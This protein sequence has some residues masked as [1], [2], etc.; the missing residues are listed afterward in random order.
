MPKKTTSILKNLKNLKSVPNRTVC[1]DRPISVSGTLIQQGFLPISYLQ[2]CQILENNVLLNI[3]ESNYLNNGYSE[4]SR[5]IVF[6]FISISF[7]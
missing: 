6:S 3:K 1:I 5:T 7:S 2:R 4:N